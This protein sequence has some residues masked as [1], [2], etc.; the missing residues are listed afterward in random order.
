MQQN[1]KIFW[2]L[3]QQ[4]SHQPSKQQASV[5]VSEFCQKVFSIDFQMYYQGTRIIH[6]SHYVQMNQHEKPEN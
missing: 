3:T 5:L 2:K 1:T 4:R 6:F